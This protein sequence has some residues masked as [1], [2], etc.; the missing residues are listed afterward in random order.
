MTDNATSAPDDAPTPFEARL[1]VIDDR[2]DRG[3][4]RMWEMQ[5]QIAGLRADIAHQS[6][7]LAANTQATQ[8]VR[9]LLALGRNGLKVLGALG[10][11][12][13]W[14]GGVAAAV[15]AIWGLVAQIKGGLPPK[16]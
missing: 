9:E 1:D 11:V 14:A 15:V 16:P 8:E 13:K 7:E 2:L 5:S 3:S 10:A 6:A 12:A 4:V